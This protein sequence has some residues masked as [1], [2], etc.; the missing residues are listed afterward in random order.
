MGKSYD[1]G[2][3][4]MWILNVG[5]LK[6]AENDIEY[7]L[8]LARDINIRNENI[9]DIFAAKAKRDFNLGDMDAR[10]YAEIMDEYYELANSNGHLT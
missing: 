9:D 5:D 3:D 8:K 1:M 4:K 10:K 7:F 6:P 2:A